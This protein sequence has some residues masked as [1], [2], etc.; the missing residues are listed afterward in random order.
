MPA[1]TESF[2]PAPLFASD[3]LTAATRWPGFPRF[4]FVGGHND[5]DGVPSTEL[6]QAAQT[7]LERDAH[8]L[9]TYYLNSGPQGHLPLR[10]FV[11]TKLSKDRGMQIDPDDVLIT[12]GSLQGL[13]LVNSLFIKPGDTVLVE[14][15]CY[16][17]ALS[18]LQ[19]AGAKVTGIALDDE[20]L[21]VDRLAETLE[22]LKKLGTHP[23]YLY[24]IP[25]V[26][27][28]T[29]AI[30][31][32]DRRRQLLDLAAEHDLLILEDECYADLVWSGDRPPRH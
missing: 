16:A 11:C 32:L 26:Q 18:R 12:S 19:R 6:R 5:P 4:N 1:T 3:S 25:T 21:R 24:T 28:P 10:Q 9:A 17:G 2:D 30:M 23:K 27:N 29:S 20:G 15:H 13:D 31:G 14:E 7:V 22:A 8:L